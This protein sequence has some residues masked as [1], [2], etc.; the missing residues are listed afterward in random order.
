MTERDENHQTKSSPAQVASRWSHQ[1][2]V[3][4]PLRTGWGGGAEAHGRGENKGAALSVTGA[5]GGAA[6][7]TVLQKLE[8]L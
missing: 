8:Q 3:V 5:G 6:R 7:V 2:R 1:S 4:N